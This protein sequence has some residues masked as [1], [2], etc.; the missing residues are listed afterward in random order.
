MNRRVSSFLLALVLAGLLGADTRLRFRDWES[1]SFTPGEPPSTGFS[2]VLRRGAQLREAIPPALFALDGKPIAIRGFIYPMSY[3][4]G[5]SRSFLF[6][7]FDLSC[8]LGDW[9]GLTQ[10]LVV[11]MVDAPAEVFLHD[12]VTL[13]G[14]LHLRETWEHGFPVG[15]LHVAGERT[16]R[17]EG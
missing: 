9:P 14:T 3:T 1:F 17:R 13:H 7:P 16:V 10:F 2:G 6:M 11:E 5:Y 8:H 4:D 12:P 15:L